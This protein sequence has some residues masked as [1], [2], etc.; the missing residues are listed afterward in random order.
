MKFVS[1]QLAYFLQN[2]KAK[3]NIGRLVKFVLVLMTIVIVYSVTF[4]WLMGYEGQNHSWLTGFY[5]TLTVMSTLG[6]GDITFTTD[7]GRLFSIIVLLSG[8]VFLLVLL[9]FTFIQFFYAPW[10][11]SQNRSKAPSEVD[12]DVSGH[13]ILT[14]YEPITKA[15]ITKL[16][17]YGYQY[18]LI[19]SD[20]QQAVNYY[21][22]G[23]KVLLGELDDPQTYKRARLNHAAMLVA[24]GNDMINTNVVF[25]AREICSTIPIASM[26]HSADSVDI[27]KLAGSNSVLQ[28]G[29]LMGQSLARRTLGGS[30]RVHVIGRFDKL[31]I[32]EAPATGTPLIGKTIAESRLR[33]IIGV[34]IIGIWERGVFEIAQPYTMIT[35]LSVLVLAGSVDQLRNYD[36]YFGIYNVKDGPVVIIGAG[37]VGR[38]TAKSLVDRKMEYVVVEKNPV[39]AQRCQNT[40]IGDAADREVLTQAGIEKAHTVIITTHDD[41]V[42][43][44][45]TLYCRRLRPD[46]HIISR[47]TMDRNVSTLHR[48]GADFVMSYATMGSNAFFNVLE[49]DE[50]LMIA[51]GLNVFRMDTPK[52]FCGKTIAECG[53]RKLTGCSIIAIQGEDD[54]IINPDPSTKLS[55]GTEIVLIGDYESEKKFVDILE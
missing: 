55:A 10:L 38:S 13:V 19:V 7:A 48:A 36:D 17:N 15:L 53:I 6:F 30:A 26:A 45:L 5:W 34:N 14:N 41:D 33:E 20:L 8:I 40:V 12:K 47:S 24:T 49:R 16:E 46:L 27:L 4:H 23:V 54:M 52:I 3:T 50:V 21:D 42:N 31:V 29:V 2:K 28:L 1:S 11:E 32:G 9:P 35:D 44:Y 43:I 51:E 22:M 18:Y 37:K 39:M 25:T